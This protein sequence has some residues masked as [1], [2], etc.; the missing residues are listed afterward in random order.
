SPLA[1]GLFHRAIA[2]SGFML[3]T[4]K[5]DTLKAHEALGV[6]FAEQKGAK[7]IADLRALPATDLIQL[8]NSPVRFLPIAD[9]VV[10]PDHPDALVAAGRIADVPLMTGWNAAEGA[11]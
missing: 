1:K 4:R 7:S 5:Y 11:A 3:R 10:L 2:E 8:R 9:G 6:R